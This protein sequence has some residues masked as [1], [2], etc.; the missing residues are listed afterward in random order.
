MYASTVEAD[1]SGVI[2]R[3]VGVYILTTSL[4]RNALN[5]RS[6]YVHHISLFNNRERDREVG[7]VFFEFG[8]IWSSS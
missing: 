1:N 5:V 2:I 7:D 6:L 8:K 3:L 4:H